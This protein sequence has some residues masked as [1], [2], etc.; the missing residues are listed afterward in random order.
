M[1]PQERE[2]EWLSVYSYS[3]YPSCLREGICDMRF[4]GKARRFLISPMKLLKPTS[5]LMGGSTDGLFIDF[6]YVHLFPSRTSMDPFTHSLIHPHL[7]LGLG[8]GNE[9]LKN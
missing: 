5:S 7:R 9:L 8:K 3:N 4:L 1:I 2:L 6:M